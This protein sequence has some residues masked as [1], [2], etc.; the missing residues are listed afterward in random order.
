MV[1]FEQ[2]RDARLA[3]LTE[4]AD[5]WRTLARQMGAFEKRVVHELAGPLRTS[6]W[7]GPAAGAAF[8]RLDLVDDEFEL[9][10]LQ[11]RMVAMV[12][13]VGAARLTDVQ[14][15]L[16]AAL[17]AVALVGLTVDNRGAVAPRPIEEWQRHDEDGRAGR[18]RDYE[19]ARI[20]AE[21]IAAIVAEAATEDQHISHALDRLQPDQRGGMERY[22]WKDAV[23]DA[24]E[25]AALLGVDEAAIPAGDPKQSAEWWQGLTDDQKQLYLTAYPE[26]VGGLDGLPATARDQANR[27]ALRAHLGE[28][29]MASAWSEHGERDKVRLENLLNKLETAEYGG[30]PAQQLL[31]LG[32]DNAGDGKA[33]VAVGNPDTAR[34]TAVVVPGVGTELDG[35]RGQIDRARAIQIQANR[36]TPVEGNDVAVIAWLGYDTP[37][38]DGSAIG[39]SHAQ[40]AAPRL[41]QFINGLDIAHV[42]GPSHL[43][44]LGH[45]YGST[46]VGEAASQG[47]GLTVGDIITAGSPG[48]HVNTAAELQIDP[49]H[50]WAGAGDEDD[51]SGDLG[52]IPGIHDNEPSDPDFGANQYHV[53]TH[54]HSDYWQ[55]GSLSLQNQAAIVVGRYNL[56]VLDHGSGPQ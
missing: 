23:T 26:R 16:H 42:S 54:G 39:Y 6:G 35:M 40:E 19:N 44:V 5:G 10:A 25:A 17:D 28:L 4:A 3:S 7:A 27:L 13:T 29:T 21:V 43:S 50:V 53:D 45:S 18:A 2:L 33:I 15:R 9:A 51:I 8:G 24:R 55:E 34:H 32:L 47:D 49:R 1:T 41:D 37:G 11:A 56:V 46:V 52:S 36:L 48:M 31:L 20:Y 22:E 30:P 38:P 12:L 14:K